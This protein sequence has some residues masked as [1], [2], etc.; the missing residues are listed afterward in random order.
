[1]V[2][3]LS[4]KLTEKQHSRSRWRR[5]KIGQD[6]ANSPP[7]DPSFFGHDAATET[8]P[9]LHFFPRPNWRVSGRESTLKTLQTI[10]GQGKMAWVLG[11]D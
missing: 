7:P 4:P 9:A 11:G 2:C 5:G 3:E 10:E 8:A 6:A 1:M